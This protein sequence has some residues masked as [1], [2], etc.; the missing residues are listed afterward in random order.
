[1]G[2]AENPPHHL[3]MDV[4]FTTGGL[5]PLTPS[6]AANTPPTALVPAPT[7]A[8]TN[9]LRAAFDAVMAGGGSR[10]Q[11]SAPRSS[12]SHFYSSRVRTD[13]P[14]IEP[15]QPKRPR[16]STGSSAGHSVPP[17]A[18]QKRSSKR[19]KEPEP[20]EEE[21]DNAEDVAPATRSR[22][23]RSK[24]TRGGGAGSRRGGMPTGE[25]V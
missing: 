8:T 6:D 17:T 13:N 9:P 23:G 15:P 5:S 18:T 7:P 2:D 11:S 16:S 14:S 20:A 10:A 21:E 22:R 25:P 4:D 3:P 24:A 12:H 1:M 19:A